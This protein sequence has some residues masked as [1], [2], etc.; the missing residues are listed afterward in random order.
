MNELPDELVDEVS[1]TTSFAGTPHTAGSRW[2][3][4][5][6]D[7]LTFMEWPF[8]L[9]VPLICGLGL[10]LAMAKERPEAR[11]VKLP[12]DRPRICIVSSES[13]EGLVKGGR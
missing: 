4:V 13:D 9:L 8:V 11:A 12:L 2:V 3:L 6:E 7:E 5:E 10:Y 1:E